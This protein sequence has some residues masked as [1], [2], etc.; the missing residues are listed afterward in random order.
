MDGVAW[1]RPD[2]VTMIEIRS[3]ASQEAE[4]QVK[5]G[6]GFLVIVWMGGSQEQKPVVL[7]RDTLEQA[8]NLVTSI[9]SGI[10][11]EFRRRQMGAMPVMLGPGGPVRN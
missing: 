3:E 4:T 8:R 5:V 1:V 2:L 7:R 11:S 6:T 9:D 10:E